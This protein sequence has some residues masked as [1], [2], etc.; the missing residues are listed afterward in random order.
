MLRN[1]ERNQQRNPSQAAV[2]QTDQ[3]ARTPQ[4]VCAEPYTE[5]RNP[6]PQTR[7]PNQDSQEALVIDVVKGRAERAGIVTTPA[8]AGLAGI[9]RT[10]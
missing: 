4:E 8:S 6:T 7:N 2:P 9:V 1:E 3:Q 5:T 10:L